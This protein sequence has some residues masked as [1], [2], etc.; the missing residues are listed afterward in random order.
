MSSHDFVGTF[1]FSRKV[2]YLNDDVII[3]VKIGRHRFLF[4]HRY[5]PTHLCTLH[6]APLTCYIDV[7][8]S[9]LIFE[10]KFY[11]KRK[12]SS[13]TINIYMNHAFKKYILIFVFFLY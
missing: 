11:T 6:R 8:S 2:Y 1:V 4:F 12:D 10:V 9:R 13:G 3:H 7:S 5:T